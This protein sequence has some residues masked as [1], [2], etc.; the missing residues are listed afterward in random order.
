MFFTVLSHPPFLSILYKMI[1]LK[2][3]YRRERERETR[4]SKEIVSLLKYCRN[5]FISECFKS[6][7]S[8]LF[9]FVPFLRHK[10]DLI[11]DDASLFRGNSP[12]RAACEINLYYRENDR[13]LFF[14]NIHE[15]QLKA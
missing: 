1:K 15:S 11:S 2:I 4:P 9:T 13:V 14:F 12:Q 3:F 10:K 7:K 8:L 6:R 5:E